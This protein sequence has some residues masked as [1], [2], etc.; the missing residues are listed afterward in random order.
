MNYKDIIYPQH[1]EAYKTQHKIFYQALSSTIFDIA[2]L[3]SCV[4][5]QDRELNSDWI[6]VKFL[7]RDLF[8]NLISKIY[9]LFFDTKGSDTTNILKY[10][11]SV[12]GIYIKGEY[13]EVLKDSVK[14]LSILSPEYKTK[15]DKLKDNV[16][17]LRNGYIGHRL[18]SASD[19]AEIDL[20]DIEQ[21]VKNGCELFQTLSFE[22]KDFYSFIEGDGHDFSK[23]FTFT[24]SL[25]RKFILHTFLTSKFIT[26]IQCEFDEWCPD[27]VK[28]RMKTI[29]DELN[30]DR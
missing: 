21:L 2:F 22:P 30:T 16:I 8:E 26:K 20:N 17:A 5:L 24:D 4:A 28:D 3:K 11:N 14:D 19:T 27:D 29:I 1:I 15:F 23:E 13:R 18:L 7:H 12:L 10:K 6:T 25:T 9:R